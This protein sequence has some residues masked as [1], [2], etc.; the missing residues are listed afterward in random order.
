MKCAIPLTPPVPKG[1]VLTASFELDGQKF[2]ALNGG[3]QFKFT[4]AIS[5]FVR[6]DSQEEIEYYWSKLS[7]GGTEKCSAAGSR[8]SSVFRG[9]RCPQSCSTSST[10]EGVWKP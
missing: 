8:T 10:R 6:Y 4:Q 5:L 1:T 7:E 9:R 2:T 3:P